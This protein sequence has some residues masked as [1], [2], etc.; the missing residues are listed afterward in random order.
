[1]SWGTKVA[2]LYL[3]FAGLIIT[4]VVASMRQDFDLVTPDY[5]GAELRYQ[6][7]IDAGRNQAA[8]SAPVSLQQEADSLRIRFPEEF[9]GRQVS[10]QLHFYAP[11]NAARDREFPIFLRQNELCIAYSQLHAGTHYTLKITWESEGK[12][13]YQESPFN[14]SSL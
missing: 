1:M 14:P 13:Y 6:E 7:V 10:G 3:G 9:I 5:Y 8:L 11:V 2:A 4:L 12:S